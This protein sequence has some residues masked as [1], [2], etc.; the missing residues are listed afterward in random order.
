MNINEKVKATLETVGLIKKSEK[1]L[2][3]QLQVLDSRLAVLTNGRL[4]KPEFRAEMHALPVERS[5]AVA[6]RMAAVYGSMTAVG[7]GMFK[8]PD[9]RQRISLFSQMAGVGGHILSSAGG[10]AEF[11]T[12][13]LLCFLFPEEVKAGIDKVID[14]M[15]LAD[16]PT[17]IERAAE[18]EKLDQEIAKVTV[19]LQKVLADS[20]VI[21]NELGAPSIE[22]MI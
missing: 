17:A 16:G 21:R 4:S 7:G 3:A 19:E 9:L 10:G 20:K 14:T 6:S 22:E 1:N 2:R 13:A 15:G 5:A 11:D 12:E 8:S 18:I